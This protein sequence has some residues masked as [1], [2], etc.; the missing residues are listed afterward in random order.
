MADPQAVYDQLDAEFGFDFDPCP[1]EPAFDGLAVAWGQRSFAN[2]PYGRELP[3]W[4]AKAHAEAKLGKTVVLL[5]P[6]RTDTRWWHDHVMQ[7]DEI[8]YVKGRLTFQGAEHPAPFPS[9][10]VI[11]HGQ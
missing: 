4:I 1:P 6:S 11:W 9:A 10:V 5:I 7:A 3:K 2:P 8:R